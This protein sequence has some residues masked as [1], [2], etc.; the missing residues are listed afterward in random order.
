MKVN[1][2]QLMKILEK[3]RDVAKKSD[4]DDY[5]ITLR[6]CEIGTKKITQNI[7]DKEKIKEIEALVLGFYGLMSEKGGIL[8]FLRRMVYMGEA[9]KLIEEVFASIEQ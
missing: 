8:S 6:T 1:R 3:I 7:T 9:M 2:L 4:E 5:E